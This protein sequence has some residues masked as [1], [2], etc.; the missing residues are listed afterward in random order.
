MTSRGRLGFTR[1]RAGGFLVRQGHLVLLSLLISIQLAVNWA[2]LSTNVVIIGWDRPRHLIESL[3][4]NDILEQVNLNSLFEAQTHSGYYPPLFHWSMVAFYKLFG[5]SMDVAAMANML[6]LVI[7]LV[8]AYGV[9]REL[10]GKGVGLLTAFITSTLP[11]VFAMSRYTYIEFSLM[12][13]VALSIW[14]LLL[15]R[16]FTHRGYSLLFG[17]SLGLGLLSKWTFSL[18]VFPA[19]IVVILRTVLRTGSRDSLRSFSKDKRWGAFS[20]SLGLILTLVW[21]LPNTQRIAGLPLSHLLL[22]VS[23]FLFSG[24]IY[25]LKQPSDPIVNL[26]GSLWLGVVVTG[27]WYLSRIDFVSHT[28]LI[29]WGRPERHNWAFGYYLDHLIHE[30]LSLFYVVVLIVA[31]FGLL[32]LAGRTLRHGE[33]WREIWGG[34]LLL[35]VL[36]V[37]VP[38]VVFS[39]RPSSRHSRFIMPMLP[40]LAALMA[41]GLSKIQ[42]SKLKVVAVGLVAVVGTGQ[43]LALS[44]DGMDWLRKSAVI[45][46]VEL[47]AH[48]H[49]NQ[50]PS[51]GQTDSGYWVVPDILSYVSERAEASQGG[52]ELALLVNTWQVHDEHFLYLIYTDFPQVTLRELAQNWTGRPA[53][54][55]L[56]E[57]DYVAVA[58]DNPSHR[59]DPESLD[60]VKTLLEDPP[61]L[62][63][64]AF[65]LAK[66]Y[67]LPDGNIIYLY[68]RRYPLPEGYDSQAY[69]ALARDLDLYLGDED[70]LVLCPS[71]QVT[72]LGRYY[73]G[74]PALVL[75]SAQQPMD[76]SMLI[77]TLEEI[78]AGHERILTIF[79]AGEG[80]QIQSTVRPWLSENCFPTYDAWYGPAHLTLYVSPVGAVPDVPDRV[81]QANFGEG[82]SLVGHSGV[83]EKAITGQ[84]L[85]LTFL[86]RADAEIKRDYKV[87]VHLLDHAGHLVAQRDG[88]PVGG[89]RSTTGWRAGEL[90]RDHYGLVIP[91]DL[92]EGEYELVVGMYDSDGDRLPVLDERGRMLGN[93]LSLGLIGVVGT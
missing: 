30:Q 50:L 47:F 93:S 13:M 76:E 48:K 60:V 70:A 3:V 28:F 58:S 61:V 69:E 62:F 7:L 42:F 6:F 56:F 72:L 8:S 64:E 57:V 78:V 83:P 35:L 36:W 85:R 4:Y 2:W 25:L 24:L 51:S 17:L 19:L 15:S 26:L 11:M 49:Q 18:F 44:F 55:Q 32:I 89:S 46:G 16:E 74:N 21:Y 27:S 53:Y 75:F 39:F 45:G 82:I 14:L 37:V 66:E 84:I 73:L 54:P 77:H 91:E 79:E 87:L 81:V 88:E 1:E 65:Q 20:V 41:Y 92:P 5:V 22:P 9:G 12:A 40:A 33:G 80:D 59:I 10:G 34:K 71:H 68:E 90:I 63:Q 31:S 67:P 43:L 52:V 86:W 38:Y 23:W 29:A